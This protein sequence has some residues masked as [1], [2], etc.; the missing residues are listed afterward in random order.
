MSMSVV[1]AKLDS[2][3]N[4]LIRQYGWVC[5]I[6]RMS[7]ISWKWVWVSWGIKRNECINC[8][9]VKRVIGF[10]GMNDRMHGW[11]WMNGWQRLYIRMNEWLGMRVNQWLS[12]CIC[13]G[14]WNIAYLN[15][16]LSKKKIAWV[17]ERGCEYMSEWD[18]AWVRKRQLLIEWIDKHSQVRIGA[19]GEKFHRI[20]G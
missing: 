19:N 18:N 13:A 14:L 17:N 8:Q 2:W 9:G 5:K 1:H 6:K 3:W 11:W 20:K 12:G 4:E 15:V 16:L 10:Q 7:E